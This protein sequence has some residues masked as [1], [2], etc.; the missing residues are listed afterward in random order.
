MYAIRKRIVNV[1]PNIIYTH[2]NI[3]TSSKYYALHLTNNKM[4]CSTTI[5]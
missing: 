1:R 4:W 2:N 3:R 5:I